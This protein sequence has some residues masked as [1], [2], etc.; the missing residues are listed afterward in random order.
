MGASMFEFF[1][2]LVLLALAFPII[3]I[4]APVNALS[5]RGLVARLAP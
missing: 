2:I 3:A 4:I 5:L 1:V